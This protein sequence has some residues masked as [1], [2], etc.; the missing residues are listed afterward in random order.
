M[1]TI[2]GER[3]LTLTTDITE[4]LEKCG[5]KIVSLM[6]GKRERGIRGREEGAKFLQQTKDGL[7]FPLCDTVLDG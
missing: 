3:Y 4:L 5:M 1:D 2:I 6:E 7:A